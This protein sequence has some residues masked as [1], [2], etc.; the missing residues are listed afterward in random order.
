MEPPVVVLWTARLAIVAWGLRWMTDSQDRP[1]IGRAALVWW[2]AGCSLHLLHVAAAYRLVHGWSHA[3]AWEHV[4][5]R[6]A[7][8]TGLRWGGGL[9]LNDAFTLLW[10]LDTARLWGERRTGRPTVP[11]WVVNGWHACSGFMVFNATVVFGPWWWTPAALVWAAA[12]LW[13]SRRRRRR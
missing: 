13:R 12:I 9:W 1:T 10:L 6:T 3:A 2:T 7:A 4:A 5:E 11:R 8:V